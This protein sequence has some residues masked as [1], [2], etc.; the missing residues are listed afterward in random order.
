MPVPGGL[1]WAQAGGLPE[2]FTTAHDALFTQAGLSL[3]ERLLVSGAAGGV[4]TAG[5]QLGVAAGTSVTATVRD[6]SL[7]AAVSELGAAA[8][9]PAEAEERGP[10][11]VVLELV[12]TA[13]MDMN[14]RSLAVGGRICVIGGDVAPAKVNLGLL[15]GSRGRIHGSTLRYRPA[16]AKAAA[17]RLVE[18]HVI[19]L[20]ETGRLRVPV[21]ST[22]KLEDAPAAYQRFAAG[23]K[24][25]KVVLLCD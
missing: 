21:D 4:G 13:S 11:D 23:G 10:F 20:F 16:G 5:L 3:G 17:A 9:D 2:G 25:G 12:G 1:D 15:M 8:I 7:R 24:L 14:L 6:P 18:A 22:F 19:P